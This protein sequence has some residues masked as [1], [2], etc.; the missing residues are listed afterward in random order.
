MIIDEEQ[1][2][3]VNH[4]EQ[5]KR[6][7][8]NVDVLSLSATPIPRTLH[9]SLIGVRDMSVL[10]EAPMERQ[11]IQTF[12]FEYNEEMIR[13]AIVR[14]MARGGQVYYV[15]N[16]VNQIA[17]VA[18]KVESLVPEANVAYAHGKMSES[19]LEKIMYG[20][21]NQE[22]DVLVSTTIIEIGLDI[23]NVNTIIIH[24][25]D[26]LGLSQLYQLRG[27]VGRSNRSAYAFLM[28]KRD[29]MLKEVAEKRLAA[30][31]E[32][33][34]LGS[35]FKIAMRDLEIRGAG[36]MLGQEQHG[37]MAAVGYDL[38]CKM[39]NEAV[40]REKGEVL[41]EHFD[42]TVDLEMD[43]YLPEN[44]VSSEMQRLDLYKRIAEIHSQEERDEMLDELI[45]R[46]GEPG[47]PVQNL[48]YIA[49]LRTKAH[50]AF[51]VD[52]KQNAEMIVFT[53]F[54]RAPIDPTAIPALVEKYKPYVKFQADAKRP[55]FLY[56]Y[57]K[58]S[59][60]RPKDIPEIL[61][62]FVKELQGLSKTTIMDASQKR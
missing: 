8:K 24:D 27:R 48:L 56:Y 58:N 21:I 25:S 43:A 20:F 15:F 13:E 23:S 47:K 61:M 30:I 12:V 26:Q 59:R 37:H 16:R 57:K 19:R 17:D 40:K 41:E 50:E 36:N 22:I 11:P 28:Y 54:E 32:F 4:K 49:M 51:V 29:K 60:I 45:D 42:T 18:A 62:N 2:F 44:Y 9:M 3:G 10:E 55:A 35:G 6:M 33:T 53:M 7:K 34:D 52:I 38:Y 5:I 14:E 31:K 39:L 46:F 1:R